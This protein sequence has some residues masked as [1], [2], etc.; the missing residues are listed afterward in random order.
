MKTKI[1]LA[2]WSA[3]TTNTIVGLV[4][5]VV[6]LIAVLI[7]VE[8]TF[9]VVML[10]V[11]TSI[12]ASA[13]VSSLNARYLI[14]QNTAVQTLERWGLERIYETRAE[15]NAETNKLLQHTTTLDICAMGLKGFR[16]AQ[17]KAIE[18]R[19][20]EGMLLKI[21]TIDPS[22]KILLDIDQTE[23]V[24]AGSTQATII[25]LIDWIDELKK[26]QIRPNQIE[27]KIYDHY[28][29]DFYFCMDG[30]VFT[31]PYQAK[32]SQQTITYKYLANTYGAKTFID[33]YN[34]LW[35][36]AAYVQR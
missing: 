23:G 13:I 2:V 10:S 21:L 22:S 31:G 25:S 18:K 30:I 9:S 5:A 20:S 11:G 12:L 26:I 34:S 7:G 6:I 33:Y 16:D 17:G 3:K 27:L 1:N 19:I 35:E 4:G 36:K 8:K 32:T 14:Q 24:A 28:P 15:I 29:Y